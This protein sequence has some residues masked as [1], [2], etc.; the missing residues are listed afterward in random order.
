MQILFASLHADHMLFSLPNHMTISTQRGQQKGAEFAP[1]GQ[2]LLNTTE[3]QY[4]TQAHKKQI[5]ARRLDSRDDSKMESVAALQSRILDIK[6]AIL[7]ATMLPAY[8]AHRY[9]RHPSK[10]SIFSTLGHDELFMEEP[11]HGTIHNDSS[12][13]N[14]RAVLTAMHKT[15]YKECQDICGPAIHHH[16][17]NL[18]RDLHVCLYHKKRPSSH[19]MSHIAFVCDVTQSSRSSQWARIMMC[20]IFSKSLTILQNTI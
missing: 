4:T 17:A 9:S 16:P 19:L 10:I 11:Q 2:L 6:T 20:R 12:G 13:K 1:D 14:G 18:P 15:L 3:M 5:I 7:Q 8:Q